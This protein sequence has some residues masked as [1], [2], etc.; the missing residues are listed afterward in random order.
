MSNTYSVCQKHAF[1]WTNN[2]PGASA[3]PTPLVLIALNSTSKRG[4]QQNCQSYEAI[5]CF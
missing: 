4:S 5:F 1:N 2:I 3:G